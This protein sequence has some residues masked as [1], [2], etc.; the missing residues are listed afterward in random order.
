MNAKM[1]RRLAITAL[2]GSSCGLLFGYDIGA[3][4]GAT[5][6]LR[7]QFGLSAPAL[8]IAVSAA[9][10]G[11]IAG[12]IAAGYLADLVDRRNTLVIA[13]LVY[14][15]ATLGAGAASDVTQFAA[16]RVLCGVAIGLISVASPMYLAEI[17]P[18]RLRGRLVGSFQLSVSLG[19]VLAFALGY[20]LS[21]HSQPNWAWRWLVAAGLVPALLCEV[22]LLAAS[23]SPR[24]LTLKGRFAEAH[25]A[26]AALGAADTEA[27]HL[28]PAFPPNEIDAVQQ[29]KLFSR[30]YA[31]PIALAVSIAMFN[32]LSGVNVLLYYI[33]DVFRELGS[34]RLNGRKDAILIA[35]LSLLVTV[36]AV[37]IIDKVGRK[38]LLLAG[39]VGMGACLALLPTI[40]FMHWPAAT[41][42]VVLACYNAFFG[43]SQGV[44]VWVYLSEI[45]PLPVRARGQGLGSTVHWVINALVVGSFPALSS[46]LGGRIFLAFAAM[47]VVQFFTILFLYPETKRVSLESLA[48]SMSY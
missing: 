33:L 12:S 24:W 4:V 14:I 11:T 41:V 15:C 7:A 21:I 19:V 39:A 30:R 43:F 37:G 31:R 17:S 1:N 47:M 42:I 8:G 13:C 18:A 16:C 25:R 9:L 28:S 6:S 48:S 29:S 3:I 32:Q 26:L 10:F 23:P 38:P 45:F 27:N 40:R 34:G 35:S 46:F 20:L 5:Q 2:A 44:V 22:L 36:V